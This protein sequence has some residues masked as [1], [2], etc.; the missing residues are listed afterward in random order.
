MAPSSGSGA[1]RRGFLAVTYGIP[2]CR[3]SSGG[4]VTGRR[5]HG[6]RI[7]SGRLKG[8]YLTIATLAGQFIIE[9]VLVHWKV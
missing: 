1:T 3:G 9:Y 2:S 5:R 7:P 4:A 6:L 8:L